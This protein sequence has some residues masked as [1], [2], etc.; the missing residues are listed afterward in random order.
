MAKFVV[1]VVKTLSFS[2]EVI[3]AKSKEEAIEKVK[4]DY[5]DDWYKFTNEETKFYECELI[6]LK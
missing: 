3:E 2:S 6:G 5:Y 4:T 1:Q